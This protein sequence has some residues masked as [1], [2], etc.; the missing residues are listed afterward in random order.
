MDTSDSL[1]QFF[2][3]IVPGSLFILLLQE[4]LDFSIIKRITPDEWHQLWET[5][6]F[7][8]ILL[9]LL[10]GFIFQ[11]LTKLV[12][13]KSWKSAPI[14]GI[15]GKKLCSRQQKILQII[16][17]MNLNEGIWKKVVDDEDNK[18][19]YTK[20][21]GILNQALKIEK[22]K[23][24]IKKTE[25]K[26]SFYLMHNY[27]LGV[28]KDKQPTAYTSRLAFWA[29]TYFASIF[30]SLISFKNIFSNKEFLLPIIFIMLW[31]M[32]RKLFLEYLRCMNDSVLNT[33]VSVIMLD[34]KINE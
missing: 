19:L 8:I 12:R 10:V 22:N 7:F 1:T 20:S 26:K 14:I 34:K 11:G 13:Q 16:F 25:Y 18:L 32:S 5:Q 9:G 15:I 3:N 23:Q 21:I 29:N 30:L 17:P 31:I 24:K 6:I 28:G 27:L 33:F 4:L 2:Y